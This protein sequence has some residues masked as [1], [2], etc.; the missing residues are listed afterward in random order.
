MGGSA[1]PI[2]LAV[3]VLDGGGSATTLGLVLGSRVLS[4]VV[5]S[6]IAGVWSDR[7]RRK[8]VMFFA[9]FLRAILALV[10]VFAA[11]PSAPA[12]LL[13]LLV[14]VMGAGDAFVGPAS[15]AILPTILPDN[16]LPQ[17]NVARG[18]VVRMASIV[19]PGVGGLAIAT[20]GG[21]ATFALTSAVFFIGAALLTQIKEPPLA[22][23][24]KAPSFIK[25]LRE[26]IS[27]VWH[28]PW[29]AACIA[30]AGVQLM[31]S[32]AAAEVL[33][34]VISRR[35]FGGNSTFAAAA[36]AYSIGGALSAIVAS[37][38]VPKRPGL[39]AVTMWGFFTLAP[40]A[41]AFPISSSVLIVGYLVAGLSVGPW[42]AYWST[43]IQRE[44]PQE[45]QGRVF[46]V[47]YMGSVGLMPLG[48]ALAGP[49]V[50]VFGERE[51]LLG[52]VFFHILIC[53]LVLIV[54]GVKELRMPQSQKNSSLGEQPLR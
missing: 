38:F 45:L 3:V 9:D 50:S 6:P 29:V 4:T 8:Y 28:I 15:G 44:I 35:E 17:G 33:L 41:L 24:N 46:S 21:R 13:A 1:F 37:R 51:F 19:G 30:M 12:W 34:P 49:A 10:L 20:I 31:V 43:A 53:A 39:I 25:E 36:A 48:M 16:L 7:V 14:F 2:A 22:E 42:E 27:T 32:L 5:F 23:S 52:S 40:L 47:D 26:G 11:V 54:P 18:I